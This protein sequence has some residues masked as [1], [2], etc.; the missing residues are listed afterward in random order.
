VRAKS[1]LLV[2]YSSFASQNPVMCESQ[3]MTLPPIVSKL[4]QQRNVFSC[5]TQTFCSNRL[6]ALLLHLVPSV[7]RPSFFSDV[8]EARS[9]VAATVR[10]GRTSLRMCAVCTV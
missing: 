4:K 7:F 3:S 9:F 8:A 1:A 5:I 10:G 2:F 6:L